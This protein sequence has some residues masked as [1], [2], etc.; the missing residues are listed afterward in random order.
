MHLRDVY[1]GD[2]SCNGEF[3]LCAKTCD[4]NLVDGVEFLFRHLH[5]DNPSVAFNQHTHG[6]VANV[7]EHQR[8]VLLHLDGVFTINV[9]DGTQSLGVFHGD[10]NANKSFSR[11]VGYCSRYFQMFLC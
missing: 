8:L 10:A 1:I 5:V 2:S 11:G 9:S 6:F 4:N 7:R 3:L